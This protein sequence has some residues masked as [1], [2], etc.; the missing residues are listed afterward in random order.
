MLREYDDM[1]EAIKN[2]E[3]QELVKDFNLFM[4]IVR[5]CL[6]CRKKNRQ[7]KPE[8]RKKNKEKLKILLKCSVLNCKVLRFIK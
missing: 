8:I 7:Q 6:K 4:K 5:S 2:Q 1:K 3:A